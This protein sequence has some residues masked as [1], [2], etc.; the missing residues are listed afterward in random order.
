[1]PFEALGLRTGGA[2][3]RGAKGV[4]GGVP[5]SCRLW[6][7]GERRKLTQRG[8]RQSPAKNSFGTFLASKN[9]KLFGVWDHS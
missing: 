8:P 9:K 3:C 1:M 6:G 2:H 7:L 4:E 5:L